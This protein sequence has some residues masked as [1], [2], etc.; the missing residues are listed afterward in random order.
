M[1]DTVT[2]ASAPIVVPDNISA[3]APWRWLAE[4]WRDVWR[5]PL[6]S[7]GYGAV[8]VLAGAG[9]SYWLFKAGLSAMI[10]V[11]LGC[12]AMVGP[13][14]AVGLYE[15]SDRYLRGERYT[16][17]QILF[18]KTAP[19]IHI[20]YVGFII[21]FAL[22]VWVRI[23]IML[24]ALF[25]SST[26][27]PLASFSEFVLGTPQGL[28]M[29]V[30]GSIVGAGIAFSIFAL[31]AFSVPMLMDRKMDIMEAT[32]R[33]I[34]VIVKNPAPMILWAWLIAVFLAVG[35]ATA[36]VGLVVIVPLL[37]HATWHAYKDVFGITGS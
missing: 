31:T 16:L 6:L 2:A 36:M 1:T 7:L 21:M 33:S 35:L 15:M 27:L 22:L 17:G 13:L 32:V 8:F 19:P 10:P 28:A 3:E 37:G 23:A 26:Y 14:V 5:N 18:V 4:G 20:A 12:F 29:L 30:V 34:Q 11:A 25:A 9:I 24:Y